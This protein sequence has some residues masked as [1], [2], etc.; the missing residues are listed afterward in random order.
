LLQ[1]T[2]APFVLGVT[3]FEQIFCANNAT[4]R[5]ANVLRPPSSRSARVAA[6]R[7]SF[8][9]QIPAKLEP[10]VNLP[11]EER[12]SGSAELGD[13]R[14]RLGKLEQEISALKAMIGEV[15]DKL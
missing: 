9:G 4:K 2:H 7:V 1:V 14:N 8:Y 13:V 12:S 3:I 6:K 11:V 10:E 15:L 5:A